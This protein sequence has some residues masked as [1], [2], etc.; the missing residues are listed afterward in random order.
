MK[1]TPRIGLGVI[2]H[3][4]EEGGE[5]APQIL[6]EAAD[7][8]R[9]ADVDVVEAPTLVEDHASAASVGQ[10]FYDQRTPVIVLAAATWSADP[11]LLDLLEECDVPIVTWA[12]PGMNTG[13]MCGSQQFCYVLNELSKP[14]RFVFGHPND[15]DAV[16]R[17]RTYATAVTLAAEL[18]KTRMGLVGY[19]IPGMT[20]VTFDELELKRVLGPRTVHYGL[21]TIAGDMAGVPEDEA[22]A[23]WEQRMAQVKKA[24][25][26]RTEIVD[27]MRA[28]LALKN[29]VDRDSLSGMAV[30]C[31]PQFMGRF[32]AAA[33]MLA[34]EGVVIGCEA[35][36]NST[37]AMLILMR[38]TGGPVHNTDPLGV[39]TDEGSIVYS[40][41][42][43]GSL[44]LAGSLD[45]VELAN[46]R[47]MDQGICVL[48]PGKPG[49][50]T[51]VTLVGRRGT[52]RMG[53]AFG[54]AIPTEMVFAGNPTKVVLEGGVQNHLDTL[55]REGLGHHWMIGYGDVRDQLKELCDVIR[56][57]LVCCT[58]P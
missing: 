57:P 16:L 25:V 34:D 7:A 10:H 33:S 37:V 9:N 3:P 27:S 45:D 46:V 32:C 5:Q 56:M 35:D 28:Y 15:A 2:R 30:E 53:I 44:S 26:G 18:R 14:Y 29:L 47:L 13:S 55:A 31:Y 41:C 19:R 50:V 38:L 43:S 20:E 49:P 1:L 36:M 51:L 4:F 21:E 58:S 8:L 17:I 48:F 40:H 6:A 24:S 11:L 12:L 22:M 39:D 42:G 23:V 54:Q 52:Y